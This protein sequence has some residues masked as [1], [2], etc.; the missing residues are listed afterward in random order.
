MRHQLR[1]CAHSLQAGASLC[2]FS[3]AFKPW[4]CPETRQ[5]LCDVCRDPAF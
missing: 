1:A 4:K 3:V 5:K 2:F